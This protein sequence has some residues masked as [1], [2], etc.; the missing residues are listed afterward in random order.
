MFSSELALEL[1]RA[2]IALA[3]AV[4]I[5]GTFLAAVA[6]A[7]IFRAL[8][9]RDLAGRL[10]GE[11]LDILD[12]AKFVA[13]GALLVGVLLEVQV[14][15]S[16]LGPRRFARDAV[17]FLLV[18]SHVYAV[19]VVQPRMRYYREKV[20]DFDAADQNDPWRV[21]FQAQHR[22]STRVNVLGLVLAVAAVLLG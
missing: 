17:L 6:A 14:L 10:F 5:G 3:L 22:R 13:A 18:A 16:A 9:S 12:K 21:K 15:G 11:I 7:K 2:G 1:S 8:P 20:A 4:F 19:M